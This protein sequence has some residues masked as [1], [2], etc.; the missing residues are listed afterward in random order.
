MIDVNTRPDM[1]YVWQL[2]AAIKA[3]TAKLELEKKDNAKTLVN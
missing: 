1:P 3:E 2:V